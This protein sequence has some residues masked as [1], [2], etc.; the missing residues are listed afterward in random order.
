M[1]EILGLKQL[2]RYFR[3]LPG[4]LARGPA[5]AAVR[6]ATNV[7]YGATVRNAPA[8]TGEYRDNIKIVGPVV[9]GNTVSAEVVVEAADFTNPG[10]PSAVEFGNRHQAAHAPMRRAVDAD[11]ERAAAL[12]VATFIQGLKREVED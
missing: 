4:T 5:L 7:L 6:A 11:G 1:A 10:E 3:S 12:A 8:V 2:D 9:T